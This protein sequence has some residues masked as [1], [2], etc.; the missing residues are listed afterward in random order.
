MCERNGFIKGSFPF[1]KEQDLVRYK[2]FTQDVVE[3]AKSVKQ[4]K[5]DFFWG[6]HRAAKSLADNTLSYIN[7]T[8]LNSSVILYTSENFLFDLKAENQLKHYYNIPDKGVL[9]K[10]SFVAFTYKGGKRLCFNGFSYF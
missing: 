6:P 2:Y 1:K 7:P 8:K 5:V 10:D 4:N 9:K 3:L